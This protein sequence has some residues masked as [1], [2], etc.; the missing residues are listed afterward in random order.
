M[1]DEPTHEPEPEP[2]PEHH[3]PNASYAA[4]RAKWGPL[5]DARERMTR[6]GSW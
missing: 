4:W 6:E 2:E 5:L 1:H 3:E